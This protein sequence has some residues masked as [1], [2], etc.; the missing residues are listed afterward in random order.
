[1]KRSREEDLL[2]FPLELLC[3]VGEHLAKV[4]EKVDDYL[5][6]YASSQSLWHVYCSFSEQS[7]VVLCDAKIAANKA[8]LLKTFS[9]EF[10]N[11]IVQWTLF[12]SINDNLGTIKYRITQRFNVEDEIDEEDEIVYQTKTSGFFIPLWKEEFIGVGFREYEM[13]KIKM[14]NFCDTGFIIMN[15]LASRVSSR[16]NGE[17]F[18]QLKKKDERGCYIQITFPLQDRYVNLIGARLCIR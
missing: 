11:N 2:Y 17:L 4:C 3:L 10:K 14:K 13:N 12:D 18:I 16:L 9:M 6:F 7:M 8:T 15:A 1:M 5:H